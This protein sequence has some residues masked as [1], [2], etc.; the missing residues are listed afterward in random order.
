VDECKVGSTSEKITVDECVSE[1]IV[2]MTSCSGSC[3][4]SFMVTALGVSSDCKCCKP[5]TS[6]KFSV[7]LTCK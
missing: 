1:K 6:E 4:S 2:E 7:T 5:A 3:S